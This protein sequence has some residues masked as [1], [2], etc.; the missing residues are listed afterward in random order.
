MTYETV[1]REFFSRF[2]G[3]KTDYDSA[4]SG[5]NDIEETLL[6]ILF[7]DVLIPYL[8]V[9]LIEQN[10]KEIQAICRFLEEVAEAARQD[11]ALGNLLRV[12]VGEWLEYMELED[13]IAPWL[14]PETKRICGYVPGLATQR[15]EIKA[16][17]ARDGWLGR[18]RW[19]GR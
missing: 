1:A 12:E 15:R 17:K 7:G 6:Y 18:R 10:A 4:M 9:A 16:K 13:E 8:K 19:F 5:P 3:S 14:G 11:G 2:P